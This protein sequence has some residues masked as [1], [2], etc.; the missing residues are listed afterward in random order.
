MRYDVF[1]VGKSMVHFGTALFHVVYLRFQW[2][3]VRELRVIAMVVDLDSD[4]IYFVRDIV[5]ILDAGPDHRLRARAYAYRRAH[6]GNTIM[7]PRC[8]WVSSAP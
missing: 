1:I 5:S 2:K 6:V 4:Q 3:S 7:N 8:R